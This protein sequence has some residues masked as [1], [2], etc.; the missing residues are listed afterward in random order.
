MSSKITIREYLNG[1][2]EGI[3]NLLFRYGS[4]HRNKEFWVWINRIVA[5]GTMIVVAE[6]EDIIVGHYAVMLRDMLI[7]GKSFRAAVD[8]H[9]IVHPSFRN[10]FIIF[11]MTRKMYELLSDKGIDFIYGFPNQNFRHIQT[12]INKW[13]TVSIFKAFEK[14]DLKYTKINYRLTS[15]KSNN[16][17]AYFNIS[18]LI[19]TRKIDSSSYIT[20]C[21]NLV[22]YINRY[23]NHPQRLYDNFFITAA[24]AEVVG[25]V[26]FKSYAN[27]Q[28][29]LTGH[30]VDFILA[31]E[32]NYSI[33]LLLLEN[34][35]H[36]KADKLSVWKHSASFVE[37]LLSLGY[38]EDGFETFLGIKVFNG[39]Q[40]LENCLADFD[41]WDVTM[42]DSDVF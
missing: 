3:C 35:F 8:F 39:N 42:G 22:Y 16:Y 31:K 29:I 33:P 30:L 1:D 7:G 38:K 11:D 17:T 20:S 41:N 36:E 32:L 24:N 9:A 6:H 18:N 25:F 40:I 14:K 27:D 23:I 12:K 15:V 37:T 5:D 13:R 2:A 10:S 26:V 34:Y 28:G 19:E 21:K 4:K